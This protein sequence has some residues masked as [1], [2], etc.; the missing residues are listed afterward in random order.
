M[1]C[2]Q[3]FTAVILSLG[4][5]AEASA[6]EKLEVQGLFSNKAVLMIDGQR[7][8]LGVGE[9]SPE[10]VRVIAADSKSATLEV[11]GQR[12]KYLLGTTIST[13]YAKPEVL[14]EQVFANQHGMYMTYGSINGQSVRFLVDTGATTVAM[15]A[16]DARRLGIQYRLN[17]IPARANTASGIA[18]AWRVTLKSVQVGRLKQKNVSA[19]VIEGSHPTEV[20][21]GMSFL[22][23]LKVQKENGTMT[24]EQKQ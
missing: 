19:M 21:L 16:N 18:R 7:H 13:R 5:L 23:R 11:D 9:T 20:L 14:K 15:S 8:I 10:G 24:L 2:L 4:L 22:E 3:I 12:K 17:G 6:V 1:S